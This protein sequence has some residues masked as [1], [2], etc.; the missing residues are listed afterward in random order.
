MPL[1]NSLTSTYSTQIAYQQALNTISETENKP[2]MIKDDGSVH[3][4]GTLRQFWESFKGLIGLTDHTER[5]YVATRLKDF[6]EYGNQKH[7]LTEAGAIVKI[8]RIKTILQ[9]NQNTEN[10]AKPLRELTD[11]IANISSKVSAQH[12]TEQIP[13]AG[14]TQRNITPVL[15]NAPGETVM[16]SSPNEETTATAAIAPPLLPLTIVPTSQEDAQSSITL[17]SESATPLAIPIKEEH[18]SAVIQEPLTSTK[19]GLPAENERKAK[20]SIFTIKNLAKIT[21]FAALTFSA[22]VAFFSNSRFGNTSSG[23]ANLTDPDLNLLNPNLD[24]IGETHTF[25]DLTNLKIGVPDVS[26]TVE[27]PLKYP[28]VEEILKQI[29]QN[30]KNV[31]I[32]LTNHLPNWEGSLSR[33]PLETNLILKINENHPEIIGDILNICFREDPLLVKA[34]T[35]IISDRLV[36]KTLQ[37]ETIL[38][39]ERLGKIT[40]SLETA[41]IEDLHQI[42]L[43]VASNWIKSNSQ[44][45]QQASFEILEK[46]V[47]VDSLRRDIYDIAIRSVVINRDSLKISKKEI[48]TISIIELLWAKG[49]DYSNG[50]KG[51]DDSKDN[52]QL[53]ADSKGGIITLLLANAAKRINLSASLP[54]ELVED[55]LIQVFVNGKNRNLLVSYFDHCIRNNSSEEFIAKQSS[56]SIEYLRQ[57]IEFFDVNDRSKLHE[58]VQNV[59]LFLGIS[60]GFEQ[61]LSTILNSLFIAELNDKE[62][63]ETLK[64]FFVDYLQNERYEI[65]EELF[66]DVKKF[67]HVSYST[68][69][70]IALKRI[71]DRVGSQLLIL[72]LEEGFGVSESETLAKQLIMNDRM[73]DRLTALR[74]YKVLVDKGYSY[75]QAEEAV[76]IG[77]KSSSDKE[78]QLANDLKKSL[79]AKQ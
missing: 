54:K 50:R 56:E 46:L 28:S 65:R 69:L 7:W 27:P 58:H 62:S 71:N 30:E 73:E 32:I 63:H 1:E 5:K 47:K 52:K 3:H 72:V 16:P 44:E 37:E 66:E 10:E 77:W 64:M 38:P 34:I 6:L 21:L 15:A 17:F 11:C 60:D 24:G 33:S 43:L 13:N 49:F 36:G 79:S 59:L 35:Q 19:Q 23:L 18:Y 22:R 67:S 2:L 55:V 76:L 39:N 31:A 78:L 53:I 12:S 68:L 45:S 40:R 48:T 75:R 61:N 41:K 20:R 29:R 8:E 26:T 14:L 51:L 9:I 42:A 25:T 57:Y 4:A 74:L 70:D